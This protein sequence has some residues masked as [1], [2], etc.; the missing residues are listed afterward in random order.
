MAHLVATQPSL[1]ARAIHTLLKGAAGD[2]VYRFLPYGPFPTLESFLTWHE[3][4]IHRDP[5]S[6]LL[7]I[8]DKTWSSASV[9]AAA[10]TNGEAAPTI[11]YAG[12]IA[13]RSSSRETL[14]TEIGCVPLEAAVQIEAVGLKRMYVR[15]ATS[16]SC[17]TSNGRISPRTRSGSCCSTRLTSGIYDA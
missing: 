4:M 14:L 7:V 13:Y 6:L 2:L 10:V 16:R 15:T 12:I 17:R 3:T 1:H 8:V 11:P 5:E 9:P